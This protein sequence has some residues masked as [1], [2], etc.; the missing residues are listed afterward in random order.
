MGQLQERSQEECLRFLGFWQFPEAW[1]HPCH[2]PEHSKELLGWITS[3][4]PLVPGKPKGCETW[5]VGMSL[6][7]PNVLLTS[8]RGQGT[9]QETALSGSRR[10]SIHLVWSVMSPRRKLSRR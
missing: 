3:F 6:K 2:A 1:G 10:G 5:D 4:Q 7:L 9:W 8:S